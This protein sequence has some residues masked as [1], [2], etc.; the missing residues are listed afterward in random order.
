MNDTE[1]REEWSRHYDMAQWTSIYVFTTVSVLLLS[2]A[3]TNQKVTDP[4]YFVIGLAFT[5]LAI[6]NTAGFRELRNILHSE[7]TDP[8]KKEFLTNIPRIRKMYMWP[9]F[10]VVFSL[11]DIAW[12]VLFGRHGSLCFTIALCVVSV[13][14][15]GYSAKQ[16]WGAEVGWPAWVILLS[17]KSLRWFRCSRSHP[18][19]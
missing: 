2:Y 8:K 10:L 4:W 13:G 19:G 15:L 12:L 16:G 11:L 3:Y 1:W 17:Q 6:Y 5:N 18:S 7:I 9:A 14:V